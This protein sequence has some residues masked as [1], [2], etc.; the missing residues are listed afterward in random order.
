MFKLFLDFKDD[1][2]NE[3]LHAPWSRETEKAG[4]NQNFVHQ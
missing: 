4:G 3:I 1:S 2:L